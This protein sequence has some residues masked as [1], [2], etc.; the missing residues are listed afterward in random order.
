MLI[1]LLLACPGPTEDDTA[2]ALTDGFDEEAWGAEFYE[3]ICTRTWECEATDM[4]SVGDYADVEACKAAYAEQTIQCSTY[5][6]EAARQCL[7]DYRAWT[8][9][10]V[11]ED[12]LPPTCAMACAFE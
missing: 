3:L 11:R 10:Q 7:D 9:D 1:A 4:S 2:T 12:Y 8:C 5:D 6:P